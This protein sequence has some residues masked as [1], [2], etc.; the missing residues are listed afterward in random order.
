MTSAMLGELLHAPTLV[1][2]GNPEAAARIRQLF[3]IDP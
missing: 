1:L 3:G 2:R